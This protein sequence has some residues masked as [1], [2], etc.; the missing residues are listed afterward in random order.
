MK[1]EILK[2]AS[3]AIY[4]E[5][6]LIKQTL[7]SDEDFLFDDL[8]EKL[9]QVSI[10]FSSNQ[11]KLLIAVADYKNQTVIFMKDGI[12]LKRRTIIH[13]LAHHLVFLSG[14]Q[15]DSGAHCLEFAIVNYV[16]QRKYSERVNDFKHCYFKAYDIHED[17]AYSSLRISISQFDDMIR[18]IEY[19]NLSELC[20]T[21]KR[22]AQKIRIKSTQ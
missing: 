8:T 6:E 21:A 22:L 16:L 11:N 3:L 5:F 14:I 9:K 7:I 18:T 20:K 13:E 10:S 15:G 1:D 12:D 17:K 2:E 19:S 4:E